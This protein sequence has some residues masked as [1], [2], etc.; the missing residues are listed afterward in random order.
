MHSSINK[1]HSQLRLNSRCSPPPLVDPRREGRRGGGARSGRGQARPLPC[2][3]PIWATHP[4]PLRIGGHRLHAAHLHCHWCLPAT[5]LL[6]LQAVS[7][8]L[9]VATPPLIM[10]TPLLV[11]LATTPTI[12]PS[13]N[14]GHVQW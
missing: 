11:I 6:P 8:P 10:D 3:P 1:L 2:A 7:G 9:V 13:I 5:P 14:C 4:Q 12:V